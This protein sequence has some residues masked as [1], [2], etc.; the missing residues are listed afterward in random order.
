MK[1]RKRPVNHSGKASVISISNPRRRIQEEEREE[2]KEKQKK[3]LKG[4]F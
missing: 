2:K 3:Y 4:I 1:G